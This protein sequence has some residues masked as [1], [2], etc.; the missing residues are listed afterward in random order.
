MVSEKSL[1]RGG[2]NN[3]LSVNYRS[4]YPTKEIDTE[5]QEQQQSG[6]VCL[7]EIVEASQVRDERSRVERRVEMSGLSKDRLRPK[8]SSSLRVALSGS[9]DLQ[10][11]LP[12]ARW[13]CLTNHE[14]PLECFVYLIFMHS[15]IKT[16][17][18]VGTISMSK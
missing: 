7:D 10:G 11:S 5:C 16:Y 9:S 2:W 15:L 1:G 3:A 14:T 4:C 8:E 13:L 6:R 12:T 17:V 18:N